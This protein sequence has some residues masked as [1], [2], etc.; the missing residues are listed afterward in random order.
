MKTFLKLVN[1]AAN[2]ES[3]K[4]EITPLDTKLSEI[5]N[6]SSKSNALNQTI[7]KPI[8]TL[9]IKSKN[10]Y[11]TNFKAVISQNL[12]IKSTFS[13]LE[14]PYINLTKL[15]INNCELIQI[16]SSIFSLEQLVYLNLSSNKLSRL[17]GFLFET[18]EELNVSNNEI[19][20]IGENI[21]TPKLI[22][23]DLSNNRLIKIDS[24]FCKNF[25]RL[26]KLNLN[27]NNI[28]YIH[29][30]LGFLLFNLK[31]FLASDNKLNTLPYSLSYLR[32]ESID[33]QN[34]PYDYMHLIEKQTV[35][36]KFPSLVEISARLVVDKK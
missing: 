30:N 18:L 19:Q 28:S 9:T 26:F 33:L 11:N 13:K 22:N 24:F 1:L 17:D 31:V 3:L 4:E 29:H 36:L 2:S 16:N 27:K 14:T 23:L 7:K 5:S 20:C 34:N 21:K 32:L 15:T 6:N 12:K 10:E 8:T 35:N 25:N